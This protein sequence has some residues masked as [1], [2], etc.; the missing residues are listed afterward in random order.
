MGSVG[1]VSSSVM[2]SDDTLAI[3]SLQC[4]NDVLVGLLGL[5]LCQLRSHCRAAG[6]SKRVNI[7][8]FVAASAAPSK[9]NL[10]ALASAN[11][12]IP[13]SPAVWPTDPEFYECV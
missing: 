8:V 7:A 6:W 5:G 4:H 2:R 10:G 3:R 11:T 9:R 13:L 1:T 12:F